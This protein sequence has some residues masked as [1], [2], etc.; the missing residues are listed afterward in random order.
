MAK[1][2]KKTLQE[3]LE[4]LMEQMAQAKVN[5]AVKLAFLSEEDRDLIDKLDLAVLSEFRRA[6]N[7][8]VEMKFTDRMKTIERLLAMGQEESAQRMIDHLTGDGDE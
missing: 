1:A 2:K 5:D 4:R 8:A 6:G 7:G 3:K